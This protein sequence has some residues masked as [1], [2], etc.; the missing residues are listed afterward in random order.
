MSVAGETGGPS[1]S[2]ISSSETGAGVGGA[3]RWG[4]GRGV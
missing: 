2:I 1:G 4:L 3:S